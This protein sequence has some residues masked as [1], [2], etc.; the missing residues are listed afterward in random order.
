MKNNKPFV[1]KKHPLQMRDL[2][3][4]GWCQ[5]RDTIPEKT[6]NLKDLKRVTCPECGSIEIYERNKCDCGNI[7]LECESCDLIISVKE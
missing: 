7:I 5:D 1:C 4:G 3:C 2:E 6:M